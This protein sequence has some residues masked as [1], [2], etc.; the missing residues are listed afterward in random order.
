[1][2]TNVL[3]YKLLISHP[4]DIKEE[5]T[6]IRRLIKKYNETQGIIDKINILPLEWGHDTYPELDNEGKG[7][8][9]IINKQIVYDSDG[10]VAIF[11]HRIGFPTKEHCS[12]TVEEIS[13]MIKENKDVLVYFCKEKIELDEIDSE[14]L[15][16]LK[17]F[18][19]AYQNQGIYKEYTTIEDFEEIFD[20]Q[21][22]LFINEKIKKKQSDNKN[23]S[24]PFSYRYEQLSN[25]LVKL[26]TKRKY[27]VI[28]KI[29]ENSLPYEVALNFKRQIIAFGP[30]QKSECYKSFA[31]IYRK[32]KNEFVKEQCCYYMSY[33][34]N[35]DV[36]LFL[37]NI[38]NNESSLLVKRGAYI[39]LS[40]ATGRID[41]LKNYIKTLDSNP[42]AASINAGYHQCHYGDKFSNEGFLYDSSIDSTMTINGIIRHLKMNT[43]SNLLLLD[44]YTLKYFI[45]YNSRSILN[46][47]QLEDVRAILTKII[48]SNSDIASV[49]EDYI[50]WLNSIFKIKDE[51]YISNNYYIKKL[52]NSTVQEKIIYNYVSKVYID[53][54]FYEVTYNFNLRFFSKLIEKD[55]KK[56]YNLFNT[57]SHIKE[58][59]NKEKLNLL[60]IGCGYGA[61]INLWHTNNKGKVYGIELSQQAINFSKNIFKYKLN[62]KTHD[63]YDIANFLSDISPNVISCFD[64][65]EHTFNIELFLYILSS[66]V[67]SGTYIIVYVPIISKEIF[68]NPIEKL[69]N[70]KYFH[71]NH[72]YYFTEDGII[73]LF[74]QY[75]FKLCFSE[76]IKEYKCLYLFIRQ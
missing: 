71:N 64:F 20:Y 61:F 47:K 72:I 50:S 31:A 69:K 18:K 45:T 55:N 35:N 65:I 26:L 36:S 17:K 37:E 28:K 15:D 13:N 21:F 2:K 6:C 73:E 51:E 67:K 74:Q 56:F 1:M 58:F 42:L 7:V 39:G 62:I 19:K 59:D 25:R 29:L 32:S 48:D 5:V 46:N 16:K 30:Q 34:K 43:Y 76:N 11:W 8:Q 63:A 57:I 66:N 12:G 14:Q 38:I 75:N 27:D 4:S 53:N 3:Q 23:Y 70:Y 44:L 68:D 60:D 33:L 40:L 9:E 49:A 41:Y 52:P 54:D 10:V 24:N 22:R